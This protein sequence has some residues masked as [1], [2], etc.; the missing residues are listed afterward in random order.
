MPKREWTKGGRGDR[1]NGRSRSRERVTGTERTLSCSV[2]LASSVSVECR[3]S[4]VRRQLAWSG[5]RDRE[6]LGGWFRLVRG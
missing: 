4:S 2:Q 3:V 5:L 1:K 6:V